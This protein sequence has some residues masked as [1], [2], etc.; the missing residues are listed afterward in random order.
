M[1]KL[2]EI[3]SSD[4]ELHEAY[5]PDVV[6]LMYDLTDPHSFQFIADIFLVSITLIKNRKLF[7]HLIFI[8]HFFFQSIYKDRPIPC[9]L[10][11][12]KSD[13]KELTQKYALNAELFAEQYK[14]PPPQYF[15][16]S[17]QYL[18]KMDIYPKI[19]A[20]ASYP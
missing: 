10:V 7:S 18:S 13:Q 14:L 15:S 8:L 1:F 16:A 5:P 11:G 2:K 20:I 19:V 12:A 17:S 3:N 9:L 6:I 4:L